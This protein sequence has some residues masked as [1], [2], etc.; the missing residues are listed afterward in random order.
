M[1]VLESAV[2][3]RDKTLQ[4]WGPQPIWL[5]Q[6]EPAPNSVLGAGLQV[7]ISLS[8]TTL[9]RSFLETSHIG[10]NVIL[11]LCTLEYAKVRYS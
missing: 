5:P 11:Y 2:M 10:Q 4:I 1:G 9:P 8:L 6:Q 3:H 7:N